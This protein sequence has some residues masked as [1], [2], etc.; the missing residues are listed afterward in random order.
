[1]SEAEKTMGHKQKRMTHCH[2]MDTRQTAGVKEGALKFQRVF[3]DRESISVHLLLGK[4]RL[5]KEVTQYG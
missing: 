4:F 1:M 5:G 2:P 3:G